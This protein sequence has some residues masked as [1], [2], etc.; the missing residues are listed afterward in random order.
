MLEKKRGTWARGTTSRNSQVSHGGM[1]YPAG[2]RKAHYCVRGTATA[3]EVFA[4]NM[5]WDYQECGK[6]IVAVEEAELPEA[7]APAETW[8]RANEVEDLVLIDGEALLKKLEPDYSSC[9]RPCFSPRTGILDPEGAA[10]ALCPSGQ[11]KMEPRS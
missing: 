9:G 2:S 6:L 10:R 5:G 3:Q 4:S 7:G 11:G 8:A 1:Y